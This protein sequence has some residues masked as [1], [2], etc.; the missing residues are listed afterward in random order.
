M[1]IVDDFLQILFGIK[2]DT[3]KRKRRRRP[4]RFN[5]AEL[6]IQREV[7]QETK[8][9]KRAIQKKKKLRRQAAKAATPK[10]VKRTTTTRRRSGKVRLVKKRRVTGKK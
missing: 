10:R 3:S 2:S 9:L 5:P 4:R 7:Q 8:I 6:S 1:S